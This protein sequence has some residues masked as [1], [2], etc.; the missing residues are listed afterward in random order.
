MTT[1]R[2]YLDR[3]E[4]DVA[5]LLADDAADNDA[6]EVHVPRSA[7]PPNAREGD[8]L[9]ATTEPDAPATYTRDEAETEAAKERVQS[10][11]D[12]LTQQ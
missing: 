9:L 7:L 4:G 5:V 12:E 3:I 6:A 8:W 1:K 10:L 11:M 2:L